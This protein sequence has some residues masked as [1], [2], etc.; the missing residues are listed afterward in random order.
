MEFKTDT[1]LPKLGNGGGG[2]FLKLKG[3]EKVN[4][5]FAGTPH[6]FIS[7]KFKTQGAHRFRVNVVVKENGA[8]TAKIWEQGMRVSG[9][10]KTLNDTIK[11]L[12]QKLSEK[13]CEIARFGSTQ[14]DTSYTISLSPVKLTVEDLAAISAVK[15]NDLAP[16]SK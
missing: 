4:C 11:A 13:V 1:D 3:G 14:D 16:E 15:L 6:Y 9:Q 2:V 8:F 5:V 7:T 10:L 12:D